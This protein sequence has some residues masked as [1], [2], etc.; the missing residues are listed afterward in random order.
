MNI[1]KYASQT[2]LTG[3]IAVRYGLPE[4]ALSASKTV[5]GISATALSI[6]T[7]GDFPSID[8]KANYINEAKFILPKLYSCVLCVFNPKGSGGH[9]TLKC[10]ILT[11]SLTKPIFKQAVELAECKFPLCKNVFSVCLMGLG[12]LTAVVTR[13]ADLIIGLVAAAFSIIPCLGRVS[14]LNQFAYEQLSSLNVLA[15]IGLGL[16]G[17][18][19]PELLT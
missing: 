18:I 6:I 14:K 13:T 11:E 12:M 15:D 5:M 1:L 9:D 3:F 16:R 4:A 7:N 8:S 10:G 19:N 2:A 17:I